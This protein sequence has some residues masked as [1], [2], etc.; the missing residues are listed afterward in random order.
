M[1]RKT[2]WALKYYFSHTLCGIAHTIHFRPIDHK[3]HW[4]NINDA[5]DAMTELL[6]RFDYNLAMLCYPDPVYMIFWDRAQHWMEWLTCFPG[7]IHRGLM[8]QCIYIYIYKYIYIYGLTLAQVM[9]C[10]R[11]RDQTITWT[12]V[13]L[14]SVRPGNIHLRAISQEITQPLITKN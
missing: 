4:S 5:L 1:V 3:E 11:W 14:P 10:W 13:D 8:T 6:K 9:A 7:I 2:R 12:N